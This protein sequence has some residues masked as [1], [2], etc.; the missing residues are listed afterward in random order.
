MLITLVLI[1]LALISLISYIIID[2]TAMSTLV[3]LI[4]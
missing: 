3:E 4:I 2:S 1:S